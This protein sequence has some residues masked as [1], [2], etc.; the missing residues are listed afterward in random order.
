MRARV[1]VRARAF[2]LERESWSAVGKSPI[3]TDRPYVLGSN[4]RR[5]RHSAAVYARLFAATA[6][7]LFHFPSPL[8]RFQCFHLVTH[9]TLISNVLCLNA[10]GKQLKQ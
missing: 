1:C 5:T 2:V 9:V 4:P 3:T 7:P 8:A 6:L 10:V